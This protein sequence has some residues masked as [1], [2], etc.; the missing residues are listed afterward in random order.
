[1]LLSLSVSLSPSL[2]RD[3]TSSVHCHIITNTNDKDGRDRSCWLQSP[4]AHNVQGQ[5]HRAGP[6]RAGCRA[7]HAFD[8]IQGVRTRNVS[9][10]LACPRVFVENGP[11]CRL[12]ARSQSTT[13]SSIARA[14]F[15]RG[16]GRRPCDY[17][18]VCTYFAGCERECGRFCFG[19]VLVRDHGGP[20]GTWK[21]SLAV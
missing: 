14:L 12:D 7:D 17:T 1:M 16:R 9:G 15:L 6:I 4:D 20:Q 5:F 19:E 18:G 21:L 3:C 13:C 2:S 10:T 11:A 8:G